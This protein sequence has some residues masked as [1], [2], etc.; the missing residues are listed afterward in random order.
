MYDNLVERLRNCAS[1]TVEDCAG[2]PYQSDYKGAYCVDGIITEAA[3]AIEELIP[4]KNQVEKGM[5]LLDKADELLNAVK[6]HWIP[7]TE[8][9]PEE[10]RIV[11]GFTPADGYMFVGYYFSYVWG[12][13]TVTKWKIITAMRS[14]Q[15]ITKKVTH[16]MPLPDL[17]RG[18]SIDVLR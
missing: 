1:D 9:L 6:P 10:N 16:W 3:E 11:I 13:K 4:F 15:N 14:T 12:G 7:V 5:G 18:I 17:P 8:R 2:R